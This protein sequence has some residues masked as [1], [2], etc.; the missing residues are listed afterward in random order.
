MSPERT[1]YAVAIP[2]ALLG[3]WFVVE[4]A[5]SIGAWKAVQ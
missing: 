2:L 4:T 1:S 5:M 3:L